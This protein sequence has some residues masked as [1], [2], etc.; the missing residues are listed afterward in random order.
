MGAIIGNGFESYVT[1]QISI[2]QDALSATGRNEKNLRAL[3]ANTTFIRLASSVNIYAGDPTLPGT[4]VLEAM[5]GSV[6]FKW[7]Y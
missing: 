5:K 1:K 7:W 6:R 4:S 3:Q 2:R